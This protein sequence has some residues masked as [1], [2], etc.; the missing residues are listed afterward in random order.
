MKLIERGT[1]MPFESLSDVAQNN[2]VTLSTLDREK[3]PDDVPHAQLRFDREMLE[4][5]V[6]V[7][8]KEEP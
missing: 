4:G 8:Y 1:L 5:L 7:P 2:V 3:V 6:F